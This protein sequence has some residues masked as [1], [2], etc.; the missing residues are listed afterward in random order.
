MRFYIL[1]S[2]VRAVTSLLCGTVIP[3]ALGAQV[4]QGGLTVGGGMATDQRGGRSN[5]VAISP[6]LLYAPDPRLSASLGLSATRFASSVSALGGSASLGTKL[7]L[8]AGLFIAG[9]A[10]TSATRTSYDA[11]YTTAELTPTLE[12]TLASLTL[13]AGAHLARGG[14]SISQTTPGGLGRPVGPIDQVRTSRSAVG[15]VFGGVLGIAGTRADQRGTLSYREERFRVAG[16][17]VTDRQFGGVLGI[18]SVSLAATAGMRNAEDERIGFGS[19]TSTLALGR[20][21]AVQAAIGSYPSNRV[22]G[23]L[24]GSFASVALVLQRLK[25]LD[26]PMDVAPSVRGAPA[27]PTGTTRLVMEMKSAGQVEVAGDWN[28]WTP[29]RATRAPDGRWYA[30]VR[31]PRGEYRYAFRVDGRKWEVPAHAISVDDGFGGR[32]ALLTVQ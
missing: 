14:S 8:G 20:A 22:S 11:T 5:A 6:S 18:G 32:S 10:A 23:T 24:G 9:T 25:R 21:V 13:F 1:V 26:G 31:L 17:S 30:D 7:P 3:A 29:M 12:A 2:R 19:V 16:T 28:G 15:A 4:V 27:I